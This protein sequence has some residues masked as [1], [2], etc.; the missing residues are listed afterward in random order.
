MCGNKT[1]RLK[2]KF[3]INNNKIKTIME[4]ETGDEYTERLKKEN[5]ERRLEIF[6]SDFNKGLSF[7][8]LYDNDSMTVCSSKGTPE[9]NENISTILISKTDAEDIFKHLKKELN[10]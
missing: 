7:S 1:G 5:K 6:D 3:G 2:P 10:K 8:H 9:S 4:K